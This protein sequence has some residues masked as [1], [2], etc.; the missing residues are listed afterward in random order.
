MKENESDI[1][2]VL[3]HLSA[4]GESRLRDQGVDSGFRHEWKIDMRYSGQSHELSMEIPQGCS[5]IMSES[6]RRFET[7]HDDSFGYKLSGRDVEWVTARA[8]VVALSEN[9]RA[10]KHKNRSTAKLIGL[11]QVLL[12]DDTYQKSKIYRRWELAVDQIVLGP[13]IIEQLDTTTYVGPEWSA[14]QRDNGA[15]LMRRNE[16]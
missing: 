8:E 5:D 15:L 7:L 11:R 1:R 9:F 10:F 3:E 14:E 2:S 16:Q 13:S 4:E 12:N 6:I